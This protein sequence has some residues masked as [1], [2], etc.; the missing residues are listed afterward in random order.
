MTRFLESYKPDL[1][2]VVTRGNCLTAK[3]FY[4]QLVYII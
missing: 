2:F 3:H 4:W 1:I